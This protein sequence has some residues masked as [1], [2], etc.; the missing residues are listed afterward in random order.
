MD[1][2]MLGVAAAG[3]EVLVL[4]ATRGEQGPIA[5]AEMARR[6]TLGVVRERELYAACRALGSLGVECFS[7]DI[8]EKFL[9]VEYFVRVR[10]READEDWLP[11]VFSAAHSDRPS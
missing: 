8:G 6:A 4:C 2:H 5:D 10:P 3:A 11:K 1:D 9:S 7:P